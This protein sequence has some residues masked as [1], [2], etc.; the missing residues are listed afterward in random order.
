[1]TAATS[2]GNDAAAADNELRLGSFRLGRRIDE[3]SFGRPAVVA[4]VAVGAAGTPFENQPAIVRCSPTN[5]SDDFAAARVADAMARLRS[6]RHRSL[7]PILEAG[8][9]G[10]V[11][12]VVEARPSGSRLCDVL[13]KKGKLTPPQVR[14]MVADV[15]A[16]LAA[17]H[18]GGLRHGRVTPAVIWGNPD[19]A[20]SIGGFVVADAARAENPSDPWSAPQSSG[21]GKGAAVDQYQLALT[22]AAALTGELPT[23]PGGI[24]DSL[25]GVPGTIVAVL[26]RATAAKPDDRFPDLSAFASAFDEAMTHAGDDLI[27]GVWEVTAQKNNGLAAI[28]IEMAEAYAPDHRDLPLLRVR[29]AGG[30]TND[31]SSLAMASLG[32][33]M[34]GAPA[35]KMP[36]P[37]AIVTSTPEEAAIAALLMPP[38][39]PAGSAKSKGN[40]WVMFAAGT[41]A[42]VILLVIAMAMTVAYL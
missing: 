29:V 7:V 11:A 41:C 17:A 15:A 26:S 1:M 4:M 16:G 40:P 22:A 25:P 9:A 5:Q 27:A 38:P 32:L 33:N 35:P 37:P 30:D 18:A 8:V 24:R 6:V 2:T 36:E 13:A 10:D 28:M 34:P 3:T 31:I 20:A 39:R 23:R 14:R 19:G 21:G 42:C 12:Y